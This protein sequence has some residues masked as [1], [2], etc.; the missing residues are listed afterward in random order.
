[1]TRSLARNL[2][3]SGVAVLAAL[4]LFALP[5]AI[6]RVAALTPTPTATQTSTE[7]PTDTPTP[8]PT[9]TPLPPSPTPPDTIITESAKPTTTDRGDVF[10]LTLTALLVAWSIL[11]GLLVVFALGIKKK[12]SLELIGRLGRPALEGIA[13]VM[14]VVAVI[15]LGG[16]GVLK[17]QGIIAILSAIVGF[18]LGRVASQDG[19]GGGGNAGVGGAQAGGGGDAGGA[20]AG[21]GA[22][23]GGGAGGDGAVGGGGAQN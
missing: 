18:L 12:L 22:V 15:I 13:L 7:T 1:M 14:V 5:I 8:G 4:L 11:M 17:E 10:W 2:T 9:A 16:Q 23:G 19:G 6:E 21:G 20:A 3:I